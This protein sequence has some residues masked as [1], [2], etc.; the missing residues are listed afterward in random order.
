MLVAPQLLCLGDSR[1]LISMLKFDNREIML[2]T[3]DED[4]YH[5]MDAQSCALEFYSPP[6]FRIPI[7]YIQF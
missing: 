7:L 6:N 2:N 4:L 5:E 3:H 1:I